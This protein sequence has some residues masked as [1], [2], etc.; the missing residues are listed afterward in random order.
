MWQSHA[1]W[2]WCV[3]ILAV[4]TLVAWVVVAGL[5]AAT[6]SAVEGGDDRWAPR[7]RPSERLSAEE[8]LAERLALG[9]IDENQY[10]RLLDAMRGTR[11]VEE[12]EHPRPP[13]RHTSA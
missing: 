1:F 9:E 2:S 4:L 10:A 11:P 6:H 7:K 5:L 8:I 13:T 3:V 12:P